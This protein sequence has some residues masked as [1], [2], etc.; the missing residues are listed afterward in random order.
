[1][2]SIGTLFA[3][4]VVCAAVIILRVKR[5]D[6]PRPFRVPSGRVPGA[7]HRVVPVPDARACRHDLG[8]LPRLA[9]HRDGH[10]LVLR[11]DAQPAREPREAAAD[12]RCRTGEL[13]EDGRLLLAL[14]RVLHHAAGADDQL[15]ITTENCRSGTS[16]MSPLQADRSLQPGDRRRS[17]LFGPDCIGAVF[18]SDEA[19]RP[20]PG[21][22]TPT[23]RRPDERRQSW[24]ALRR[25]AIR[26]SLRPE[27][28]RVSAPA[29]PPPASAS[30]SS[31]TIRRRRSTSQQGQGRR[32]LRLARRSPSACRRLATSTMSRD[33]CASTRSDAHDGILVQAPLPAAM[34]TRRQRSVRRHRS[35]QGRRRLHPV[36]VGRL[37]QG[38]ARWRRAR[39]RASSRCSIAGHS[40]RRRAPSSSAQ[41]DRRQA[42]GDAAAAARRHRDDLPFE[43]AGP[44]G[45]RGGGRHPRRGDRPR[46]RSSR[47]S[48]SSPARPWSTSASTA[49]P[50][51]A[52]RASLFGAGSP[53]LADFDEAR[54]GGRRRRSSVGRRGRRRAD[55][56]ARRRRSAD[57]RDAP[58]E[59]RRRGRPSARPTR[60]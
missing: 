21:S 38:R 45:R 18:A 1:M 53:R 6:A 41:R 58:E 35:G 14:Q 7:R 36:N 27:C 43:D 52:G 8:A 28:R 48:S 13:P 5:P 32:R 57:D 4:V 40:D 12:R 25:A 26:E 24:M 15:G 10:L 39:P 47:P 42:D 49:S 30:C 50:T 19:P 29:G 59:H 33:G 3:F 55:A 56:G 31:A 2:T 9:R 46:R 17:S 44:A 22:K 16:S 51:R 20:G 23:P 60:S 54:I 34:G 37:V 11:P